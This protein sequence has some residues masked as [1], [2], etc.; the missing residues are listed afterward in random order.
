MVP[1]LVKSIRYGTNPVKPE[2]YMQAAESKIIE[3]LAE[4]APQILIQTSLI[5][6]FVSEFIREQR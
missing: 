6:M 2:A 1:D 4:A 3:S 5:V